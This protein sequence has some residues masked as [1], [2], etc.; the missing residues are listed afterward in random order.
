M[1]LRGSLKN[2]LL[3]WGEKYLFSPGPFERLLSIVLLPFSWIYCLI[4]WYKYKTAEE[5][6]FSIPVIGIGNLIVGG[7]GKTPLSVALACRYENAAIVLRGYGRMSKG[8]QV[9]SQAGEILCDVTTS[10][11]EAMLYAQLLPG[12]TVIVS[13][14]RIAGI[15]QAKTLGAEIVFL[16]DAY[17]KHQ[18]KKLD[19]LILS[20]Q[21]NS[22][23]LPSGP[24][25]ER[26]WKGK[27]VLEVQEKRD[28]HRRVHI[29]NAHDTMCLVTAIS[30]PQRLDAYLDERV[31]KKI[32]FP[33]HYS[34]EE[35]E[36]E[37]ILK[38]SGARSLLVTRKDGVKLQGFGMELSFLELELEVDE[39]IHR[40]VQEYAKIPSIQ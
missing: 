10:G 40:H 36:L 33:D 8:L 31:V 28:F 17:S 38:D 18:I 19:I 11:D 29:S 26:L 9:V 24:Y 5:Q 16:D 20:E 14:D 12:A 6:S 23:C 37:E 15:Q 27:E 39:G 2:H 32:Y 30:K 21:K 1:G 22:F 13:E 3:L 35:E 34:F 4:V 7:S 25:R